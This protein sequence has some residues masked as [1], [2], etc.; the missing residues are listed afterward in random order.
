M[1]FPPDPEKMRRYLPGRRPY[2]EVTAGEPKTQAIT[3]AW[4]GDMILLCSPP[5]T[6]DKLTHGQR[7][8]D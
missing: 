5:T 4:Q 6:I 3:V 1:D 7:D 2:A 8:A